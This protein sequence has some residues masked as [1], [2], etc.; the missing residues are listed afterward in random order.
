MTTN[1][2]PGKTVPMATV[3]SILVVA[4]LGSKRGGVFAEFLKLRTTSLV[5]EE[6]ASEP[7]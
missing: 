6:V 5:E 3:S 2:A 1:W 7:I 4:V